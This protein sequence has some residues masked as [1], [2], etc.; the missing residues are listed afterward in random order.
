MLGGTF[1]NRKSGTVLSCESN[2]CTSSFAFCLPLMSLL[3]RTSRTLIESNF[4]TSELKKLLLTQISS[5]CFKRK[6]YSCESERFSSVAVTYHREAVFADIHVFQ[7]K[8]QTY[9]PDSYFDFEFLDKQPPDDS[10]KQPGSRLMSLL[11]K[12]N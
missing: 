1:V 6:I 5:I 7:R 12:R 4:V 9:S 2:S 11:R 10:W 3:I 8:R